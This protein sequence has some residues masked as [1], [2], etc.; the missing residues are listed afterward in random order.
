M[1]MINGSRKDL[2]LVMR[3]LDKHDV[4]YRET[5]I[6]NYILTV[7]DPKDYIPEEIR[8][9]LRIGEFTDSHISI[10]KDVEYIRKLHIPSLAFKKGMVVKLKGKYSGFTGIVKEV[11]KMNLKIEISVWGRIIEDT[12]DFADVIPLYGEDINGSN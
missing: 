11:N 2:K 7:R 3:L 8:R 9:R 6:D 12:L 10:C 1:Y 4:Y 5:T